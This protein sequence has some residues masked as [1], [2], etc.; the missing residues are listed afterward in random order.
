M[1]VFLHALMAKS[2]M[3]P[4]CSVKAASRP[5]RPAPTPPTPAPPVSPI[6]ISPILCASLLV[7]VASTDRL[8]YVSLALT[9]APPAPVPLS[10]SHALCPSTSTPN[11]AYKPAPTVTQLSPTLISAPPAPP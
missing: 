6:R 10:A 1:S 8:G 5:A 4:P 2:Q 3:T 7:P 9:T 11:S